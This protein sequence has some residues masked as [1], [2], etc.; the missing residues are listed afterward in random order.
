MVSPRRREVL[1]AGLATTI[2]PT[3][4]AALPGVREKLILSGRLLGTNGQPLAGASVAAD[5]AQATTDAD[6]RF[7]LVTRT[8]I[9]GV[10]C[11]GH[12][13]EGFV[14]LQQRRDAQGIWR[15]TVALT[16]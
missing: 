8:G 14:P 11:E 4:F 2:A 7:M 15:A 10:T 5:G 3:V 16:L 1:V 9:Q 6:G 12:T 13:P